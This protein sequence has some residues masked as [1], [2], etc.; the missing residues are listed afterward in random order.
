M[1]RCLF[2]LSL[3]S[4]LLLSTANSEQIRLVNGGSRCSGR[5]EIY[6]SGQWGTVCD[7]GWDM[8]DAEVVCRQLGCG[9]ALSSPGNAQFGA[10]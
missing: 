8:N 5:V 7:N 2:F 9:G 6:H 4:L 3:S 1:E 10:G